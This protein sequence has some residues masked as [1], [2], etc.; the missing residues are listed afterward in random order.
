MPELKFADCLVQ[1]PGAFPA[2]LLGKDG[3][4]RK[5]IIPGVKATHILTADESAQKGFF[6]V[7]GT[8]LWSGASKEPVGVP[9]KHDF[10]HV[11]CFAGGHI[12]GPQD[13]QGEI[14]VWLDGRKEVIKR[15]SI[16]F[17]PAGVVHGPILFNKIP[18]PIYFLTVAITGKYTRTVVPQVVKPA[19]KKKYAIVDALYK[20]F[21][22]AADK[23]KK[24]PPPPSPNSTI[25]GAR[26]MH[27]EEDAV[28][29]AFYV[30]FVWIFK[31]TGA[32]PAKKH[33]HD[34]PELIAFAGSDPAKPY[35]IGGEM[36]VMLEDEYH[37]TDKSTLVCIPA[38]TQ[39]CPWEFHDIKKPTLV[40][41]AG[42]SHT[43]TGSHKKN[44]KKVPL[45]G[46][47]A[48]KSAPKKAAPKKTAVKKAVVKKKTK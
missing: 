11:L 18:R 12:D 24:A 22:V 2:E 14:T 38:H 16:I 3:K 34:W 15:N 10:D 41:T 44:G 48:K 20:D 37:A 43:Y 5:E 21:S 27:I 8:W 1:K 29:G 13:F 28:P 31:G 7:D 39:H 9:H 32:A 36:S 4:P 33:D 19:A 35:N 23:G 30:D 6:F 45:K 46:P 25:K 26:I 40:F 17:I 47:V 42:P